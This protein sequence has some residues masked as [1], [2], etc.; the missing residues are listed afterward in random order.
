DAGNV[1]AHSLFNFPHQNFIEEKKGEI[2]L[3]LSRL[4]SILEI[5]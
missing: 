5:L 1:N 3:L 2:D 4:K